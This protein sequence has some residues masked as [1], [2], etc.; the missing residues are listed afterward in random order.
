MGDVP[1]MKHII[2]VMDDKSI[3]TDESLTHRNQFWSQ[4]VLIEALEGGINYMYKW[5]KLTVN[6]LLF[7]T[8]HKLTKYFQEEVPI[9]TASIGRQSWTAWRQAVQDP[10]NLACTTASYGNSTAFVEFVQQ[11]QMSHVHCI[12]C[13]VALSQ[14]FFNKIWVHRAFIC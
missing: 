5:L 9:L 7:S 1:S 6:Y 11:K 4:S 8:Q 3:Q 13:H 14:Y 2:I 12:T 10:I